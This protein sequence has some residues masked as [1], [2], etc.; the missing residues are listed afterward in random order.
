MEV[1][2]RVAIQKYFKSKV[3]GSIFEAI[4]MMFKLSVLPFM[5]K[6]DCHDW[7]KTRLWNEECDLVYKY[8]MPVLKTLYEK[9]SGKYAKPGNPK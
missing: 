2:A 1:L 9:F 6:F 4:E 5:S 3:V 7:R 8:Y